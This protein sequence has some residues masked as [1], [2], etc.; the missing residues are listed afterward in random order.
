VGFADYEPP[1]FLRPFD[2]AWPSSVG[3]LALSR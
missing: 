2:L 3:L 1:P